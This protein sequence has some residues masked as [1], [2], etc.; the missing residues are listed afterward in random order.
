MQFHAVRIWCF[1]VFLDINPAVIGRTSTITCPSLESYNPFVNFLRLLQLP[2]Y[3]AFCPIYHKVPRDEAINVCNKISTVGA[4]ISAWHNTAV[5]Q[6]TAWTELCAFEERL[7]LYRQ[8]VRFFQSFAWSKLKFY[9]HVLLDIC[10]RHTVELSWVPGHAGIRG[11]EIA[12]KLARDGSFQWFVGTEP[13]LGIS[14]QKIRRKI[15]CWMDN[16]H[17]VLWRDPCSTQRQARE[18][19]CGPNLATSARLLSFNR[20]HSRAVIGLLTGT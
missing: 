15:K 5:T 18:K 19:V 9:L 20:T 17:L 6:W 3:W 10:T 13:F 14:R 7:I 8:I 11:N 2:S 4:A 12:D 16:Q 1:F